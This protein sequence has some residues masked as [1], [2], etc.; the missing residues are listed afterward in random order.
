MHTCKICGKRLEDNE[1]HFDYTFCLLNARQD[2]QD[3]VE[4]LNRIL[5]AACIE[6]AAAVEHE[7]RQNEG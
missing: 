1:T 2:I 6:R 7:E 5:S 4:R 3:A